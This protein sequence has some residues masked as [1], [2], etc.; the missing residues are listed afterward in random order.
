MAM[1]HYRLGQK[2]LADFE[3]AQAREKI[4]QQFNRGLEIGAGG[5]GFWFD[6]VFARILLREAI[7]LTGGSR[8]EPGARDTSINP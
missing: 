4:E 2:N 8:H 3:L 1:T 5:E 6:W 7:T